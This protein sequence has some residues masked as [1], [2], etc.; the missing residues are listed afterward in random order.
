VTV[1]GAKPR[2]ARAG[3]H[4]RLTLR[5]DLGPPHAEEQ[6]SGSGR[7]D[8]VSRVVRFERGRLSRR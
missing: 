5:V 2:L 7:P 3:K 6:F 4:G 1:S 8:F